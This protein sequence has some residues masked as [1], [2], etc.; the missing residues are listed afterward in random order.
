[1]K[2]L[3]ALVIAPPT[4]MAAPIAAAPYVSIALMLGIGICTSV[5]PYFLYT[6]SLKHLPVGTAAA[7]GIIEPMA[8][9]VFSVALLGEKPDLS[10]VCGTV[11]ILG[12]VFILSRETE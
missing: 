8:A 11:L 4:K 7:L 3:L 1:M 9:T 5:L 2:K 12:A 10:S 6:C